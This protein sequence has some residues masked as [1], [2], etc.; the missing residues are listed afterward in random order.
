MSVSCFKAFAGTLLVFVFFCAAPAAAEIQVQENY[1]LVEQWVLYGSNH[2]PCSLMRWEHETSEGI[3]FDFHTSSVGEGT[4]TDSEWALQAHDNGLVYSGS[5]LH[6]EEQLYDFHVSV[7]AQVEA[8]LL[9][10]RPTLVAA[11]RQVSGVLGAADHTVVVVPVDGAP[12][13]V[14]LGADPGVED[15][16]AVLSAGSYR[17]FLEVHAYEISPA[18]FSYEGLVTVEWAETVAAEATTWGSIKSLYR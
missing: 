15:A 18:P 3:G 9:L 8:L 2:G 7:D 16:E 5:H 6:A 1:G 14:L 17:V 13:V 12:A 10:T 11:H 4:C